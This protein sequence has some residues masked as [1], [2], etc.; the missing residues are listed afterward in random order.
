MIIICPQCSAR[1]KIP[2]SSI[3]ANPRK[4]RCAKCKKA[5]IVARRVSIPPGGFDDFDYEELTQ[6]ES[7][8]LPD[9]FA[10]LTRT[11]M[12]PPDGSPAPPSPG[13]ASQAPL[14]PDAEPRGEPT[15]PTK[16]EFEESEAPSAEPESEP[17]VD[18]ETEP[19]QEP[20]KSVVP[21]WEEEDPFD[22]TGFDFDQQN[23]RNKRIGKIVT[24]V[25]AV[26]AVLLLFVAY[27]NNWSLSMPKLGEQ[28]SF[29]FGGGERDN[30]P[31]EAW[32]LD[33]Y[34]DSRQTILGPEKRA[35]LAIVGGV[36]NNDV[37]PRS[38][39]LLRGRL[40]DA[41]GDL[42]SEVTAPC[43]HS[44]TE[45]EIKATKKGSMEAHYRKD[46]EFK[47]CSI[48]A[49]SSGAFQLVFEDLPSDYDS[50]FKVEVKAIFA[51]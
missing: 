25:I 39:I 11:S 43:G 3:G 29:A 38:R 45:K 36:V 30:I 31:E 42:R 10:F 40:Y 7:S 8:S 5:F 19:P 47:D 23:E 1:Y 50:S 49:N 48:K 6:R 15:V 22:L 2:D 13:E 20:R 46:G 37:A 12:A 34:M 17:V 32:Q 35:F 21:E 18:I 26:V 41:R 44:L 28:I 33:A 4:L 24:A 14:V 9:E 51:K 16:M 27:R